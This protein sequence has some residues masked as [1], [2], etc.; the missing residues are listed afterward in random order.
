METTVIYIETTIPSFYT[1]TR[2]DLE[3]RVRRDW[4]REWWHMRKAGQL[5]VTSSV[6]LDELQRIPDSTRREASLN[7]VAPL[8]LVPYDEQVA[9]L[10]ELYIHHR[11]MPPETGGDADHLAL[12]SLRTC[13]M[14]VT[15][16]CRHLANANK[17]A[18]VRK[19]NA[20]MGLPTPLLVTPLE[21][22]GR[23]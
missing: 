6:V 4:T 9:D 2:I 3:A 23:I 7:L 17:V 22:I 21:L 19:V 12:A 14:L 18:H 5:L 16:N 10:A 8:E 20:W 13:D 11:L 15:W 1:E